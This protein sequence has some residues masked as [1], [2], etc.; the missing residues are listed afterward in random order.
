MWRGQ[1]E[2]SRLLNQLQSQLKELEPSATG[3][4]AAANLKATPVRSSPG[5]RPVRAP[6]P[7]DLSRE[8]VVIPAPV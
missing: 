4:E 8:R 6:L 2:R 7:A 5:R 1:F 3:D